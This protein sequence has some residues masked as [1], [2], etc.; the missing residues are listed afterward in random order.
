MPPHFL[1]KNTLLSRLV[2]YVFGGLGLFFLKFNR[3]IIQINQFVKNLELNTLDHE[4]V[5]DKPKSAQQ[6][7]DELDRIVTSI[8]EMR[9]RLQKD[10]LLQQQTVASFPQEKVFFDAIIDSLP[11][12]FIV[13]DEEMK[14]ILC[15]G[16]SQ[17]KLGGPQEDGCRYQIVDHLIPDDREKYS[18]AIGNVFARQESFSL[19]LEML[20]S[21]SSHVP[22]LIKGSLIQY[23]GKKYLIAIIT[24]ISQSKKMEKDQRRA[25][26]MEAIG[27]LAGG[28]SHDFNNILSAIMGNL[29]LAQS[30]LTKP[31]KL[32]EY[33]Q[34]GLD[35][36]FRAR[37]LVEK[38][39]SISRRGQE[40]K[41]PLQ[42]ALA[43]EEVVKVLHATIPPTIDIRCELACDRFILADNAQIQQLLLNLCT[44]GYHAMEERGGCLSLSLTEKTFSTVEDLPSPDIPV[45]D[46]LCLEVRDTGCGMDK[47]IEEMM[48]EPY[49]TTKKSWAG[50][51]LG[52]AVVRAIVKG[53][54]GHISVSSEL[55]RGT[56]VKVFFPL[57][58]GHTFQSDASVKPLELDGIGENENVLLVAAE[59]DSIET[60]KVIGKDVLL[61]EDDIFNQKIVTLLLK[62]LG[63][64]VVVADN[65]AAALQKLVDQKFDIIFMDMQMPVL[66]GLQ[67]TEI[68][69]DC[70][71][72]GHQSTL[73]KKW[74]GKTV[75][76]MQGG[77]IPIIALTGNLDDE[78][79]RKCKEAGMDTFL[80]KPI[81]REAIKK[82]IQQIIDSPLPPQTEAENNNS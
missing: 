57:L 77:H 58:E 22:C 4:L 17:E 18:R 66:D 63:Y 68:V 31:D 21:D 34:S 53:H 50:T 19:E 28:I 41:E 29:Q 82:A 80:A 44:N 30:S 24:D 64:Q 74:V 81:S 42:V 69:R 25:Q 15:N 6:R 55:G 13:Y 11:G 27:T 10:F 45:G 78:S 73:F 72:N 59:Q 43:V 35:A 76:T 65:G 46:Y 12:L 3:H 62:S 8:N 38:I 33:L 61:V 49:F 71:K 2:N 37:D 36:S 26:K 67:A 51:G 47:S 70:E 7:P 54:D 39:L 52:L 75:T 20:S 60:T 14:A 23:E 48:F 32:A 1:K 40:K 9:R 5:L 16:M 56:N 79:R